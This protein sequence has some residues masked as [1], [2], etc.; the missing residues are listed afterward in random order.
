MTTLCGIKGKDFIVLGSDSQVTAGN[1]RI[2]FPYKKI[3]EVGSNLIAS[4]G[5]VGYSQRLL[6]YALR[7]LK[8]QKALN[9]SQKEIFVDELIRELSELNFNLPLEH[10]HF[11]SFNFI[12]GGLSGI[13]PKLFSIGSDGSVL[14]IPTYYADGSGSEFAYSIIAE[15]FYNE[16]SPNDAVQLCDKA[17]KQSST[18]DIYTNRDPQIFLLQWKEKKNSYEITKYNLVTKEPKVEAS[19][20]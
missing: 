8:V 19:K 17:L 18:H 13:E 2:P 14:E 10:K 15:G 6:S 3:E 16:M 4:T 11:N 1:L 20:Q 9:D 5:S 12:V 7:N